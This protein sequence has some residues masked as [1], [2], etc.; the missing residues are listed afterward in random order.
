MRRVHTSIVCALLLV[1]AGGAVAD[2]V[3]VNGL[4]FRGDR[5]DATGRP[6]PNEGRLGFFSDLYYDPVR[7]DWWALSDRGRVA[8]S[9]TTRLGFRRSRWTSTPG[10]AASQASRS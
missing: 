2:P 8:G 1:T 5:V 10:R 7:E 4:R 3:F 6:G 9:W